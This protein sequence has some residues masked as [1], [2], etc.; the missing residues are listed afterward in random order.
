MSRTRLLA[1][2]WLTTFCGFAAWSLKTAAAPGP[3]DQDCRRKN[4]RIE[5]A[6]N[7]GVCRYFDIAECVFC[8]N[9]G[10]ATMGACRNDMGG[11]DPALPVCQTGFSGA[12]KIYECDNCSDACNA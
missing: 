12:Q 6:I 5:V 7:V 2:V 1:F 8:I 11:Y 3:C 10:A 9:N 4:K